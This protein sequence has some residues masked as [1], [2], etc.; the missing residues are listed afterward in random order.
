[1]VTGCFGTKLFW[2][3]DILAPITPRCFGITLDVLALITLDV[4]APD[5]P[6]HLPPDIP[7]CFGTSIKGIFDFF[8]VKLNFISLM[9]IISGIYAR[10]YTTRENTV[11][12]VHSVK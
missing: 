10:G 6:T 1:M 5:I 3:L 2:P 4:L 12:G 7:T 11:Y 8:S 9:N